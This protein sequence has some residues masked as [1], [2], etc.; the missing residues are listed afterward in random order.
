MLT[1]KHLRAFLLILI[2][3]IIL[4]LIFVFFRLIDFDEGSY[5]SSA[6]L[7]RGGKLP[8]VDFFFPQMPYLPYVYALVS[9]YGLS[10][11][12][13]GRLISLAFGIFL[14]ILIF[15]FALRLF[16]DEKLS[17]S[18]FFLYGFNGLVL[19]W[20]AVV[21]TLVFSDL[22]GFISFVFFALYLS[23]KEKKLNLFWAGFFIGLAFNFRLTFFLILAIE[24]ITI[25]A[26]PPYESLKKRIV[27]V[28][29]LVSASILAS[30]LAIYLFFKNPS[31]FVFGNFGFHQAW[32]LEVIKMTFFQ[33]LYTFSKFVFNPQNLFLLILATVSMIWLVKKLTKKMEP[34]SEDKIIIFAL[35]ISLV[36]IVTG[37]LQE[38]TEF[39][40]YEQSLPYL[41]FS[42]VPVLS[43]LTSKW[44]DEKLVWR[45]ST[46]LYL[47]SAIPF[48]VVFIFAIRPKDIP[49]RID[50]TREVV[51]VVKQNSSPGEK[52]LSGWPGYVIFAQRESVP[53]METFGWAIVHLLSKEEVENFRLLDRK[54][55]SEM[56]LAQKVNMIIADKWFLCDFEELIEP[57]Y[58]LVGVFEFARVYIR[59][60]PKD[61]N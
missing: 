49:F 22:F 53:G 60:K 36:M 38:P 13:Y 37:F 29:L 9:P 20:H 54:S 46:V 19:S 43:K 44:K 2:F 61:Q 24:G 34:T 45:G 59:E 27:D 31:A 23:S 14:S 17:L 18:L 28:I 56:I 32:G 26:L 10:S 1:K 50:K 16:K 40:Y 4:L 57:N 5:L 3:Q 47:L 25:F 15:W 48:I 8:Y 58:H 35:S 55:I 52:I 30:P 33:K 7:V 11:L 6:Y 39:Q 42:S 51:E 41:L 12:Y 21:K